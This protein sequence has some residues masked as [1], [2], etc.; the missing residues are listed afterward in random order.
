MGLLSGLAGP[1]ALQAA[2]TLVPIGV[3]AR[4][5]GPDNQFRES[6]HVEEI[7]MGGYEQGVHSRVF[8][9]PSEGLCINPFRPLIGDYVPGVCCNHKTFSLYHEGVEAGEVT[10]RHGVSVIK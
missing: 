9:P 6:E 10:D 8:F 4:G 3:W 7:P 2:G 1:A 5:N